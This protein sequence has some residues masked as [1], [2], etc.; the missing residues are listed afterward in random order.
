VELIQLYGIVF[1]LQAFYS[2]EVVGW[3]SLSQRL[4]QAPMWLIGTSICQVYYKDASER[5]ALDGNIKDMLGKT[6]RMSAIVAL[7]VLIVMLTIGPWLIGFIFGT[8]WKESGMISRILAPWFFFDFIRYSISQT[9]LI[10]GKARNMFYISMIG[11]LCM[12]IA[13]TAGLIFF[14]NATTGFLLL[15]VILSCYSIV[16]ILW[17][18]NSVK[19]QF[20]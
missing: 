19:K 7:P 14:N 11:A 9:P 2:S 5:Y 10:I 16:V 17:I 4:L 3:F 20:P 15:S 1:L 8:S 12:I 18:V 13:V 6:I